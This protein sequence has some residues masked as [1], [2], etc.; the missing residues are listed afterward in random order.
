MNIQEKKQSLLKEN[1]AL[2]SR[3][4]ETQKLIRELQERSL[5]IKGAINILNELEKENEHS[6][7]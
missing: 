1:E 7:V 4:I 6:K 3:Y 5:E 2:K